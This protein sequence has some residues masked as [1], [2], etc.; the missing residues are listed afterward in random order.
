MQS[1]LRGRQIADDKIDCPES[2]AISMVGAE[3]ERPE[4]SRFP[5]READVVPYGPLLRR[6][7]PPARSFMPFAPAK[8]LQVAL[9]QVTMDA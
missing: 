5:L 1:G 2:S 4:S 6:T 7:V 8:A 3:S 9:H